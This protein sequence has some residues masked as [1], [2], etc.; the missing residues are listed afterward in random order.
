MILSYQPSRL[1]NQPSCRQ[2]AS[3][4]AIRARQGLFFGN[5]DD[6]LAKELSS[7]MSDSEDADE[8]GWD[9]ASMVGDGSSV[10]LLSGDNEDLKSS[11]SHQQSNMDFSFP[12]G[13]VGGQRVRSGSTHEWSTGLTSAEEK[14][15]EQA[16]EEREGA[17]EQRISD[18][19]D[20]LVSY[21]S[22]EASSSGDEG[23]TMLL[24]MLRAS[25]DLVQQKRD[26]SSTMVLLRGAGGVSRQQQDSHLRKERDVPYVNKESEY[27]GEDEDSDGKQTH[28]RD[29]PIC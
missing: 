13:V 11:S 9:D 19:Q 14:Q 22:D 17:F 24:N 8:V 1:I 2:A 20:S 6:D 16:E 5:S 12:G 29:Q 27:F 26:Q 28:W 23:T 7:Q 10:I 15:A 4:N 21:E 18:L 3:H 25:D